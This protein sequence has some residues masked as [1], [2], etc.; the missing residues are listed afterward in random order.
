MP[1]RCAA[2][3]FSFTPPIGSTWPVSVTSPVIATSLRTGRALISEASATT[4]AT[5]ADG[6]SAGVAMAVALSSLVTGKPVGADV[7]MTG[8]VTLTGQVLPVG[9][10]KEKSLAAQSAGIKR[11]IVP[12]RNEGDIAEIPEHERDG[13]E[14]VY[15]DRIEKALEAA[16]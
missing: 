15:V 9:G 6:P 14:F 8:E 10:L 13:L 12:E 16:L 11:I 3:D 2:S 1:A 7:A 4:I 5:P